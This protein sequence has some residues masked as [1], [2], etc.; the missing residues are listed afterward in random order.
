MRKMRGGIRGV[1]EP[2][3]TNYAVIAAVALPEH[4]RTDRPSLFS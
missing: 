1:L 3:A 2:A 4:Y